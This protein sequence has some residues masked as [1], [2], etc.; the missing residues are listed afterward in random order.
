[1]EVFNLAEKLEEER[2][3]NEKLLW[4]LVEIKSNFDI[5]LEYDEQLEKRINKAI[6]LLEY[7]KNATYL[8][9]DVFINDLIEIL[10]GEYDEGT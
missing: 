1:M 7:S 3:K 8:V 4:E 2:K 5:Q 6:D 9:T 10:K